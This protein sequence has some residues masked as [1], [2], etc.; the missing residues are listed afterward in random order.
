MSATICQ[1]SDGLISS[2]KFRTCLVTQMVKNLPECGRPVFDPWVGKIPGEGNSCLLAWRILR[3]E[4]AGRLQSMGSQ[5]AWWAMVLGGHKELDMTE[6]LTL[7]LSLGRFKEL[8]E[9]L[10]FCG[11]TNL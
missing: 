9:I 4:K 7:S 11:E 5:R 1:K 6:Q 2:F 8:I 10:N 3:T